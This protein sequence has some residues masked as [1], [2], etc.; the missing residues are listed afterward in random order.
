MNNERR[1][2]VFTFSAHF[3]FHFYEIAF[4][5][6]AVPLMFSLQLPLEDVLKLGFLMY[7]LFGVTSL[8]WGMFADRFG[9]RLSL[10][11]FFF[12]CSAGAFLTAFSESSGGIVFSLAVIGFFAG[13]YHPAGMGLISIGMKNRGMALG[14]NGTAGSIGLAAAPFVTGLLNW[15]VGWRMSYALIGIFG[16]VWGLLLAAC[17]IDETPVREEDIRSGTFS[18]EDLRRFLVLG[19]IIALGGLAYRINI[20]VLPAY[21]EF[22]A[23]FFGDLLRGLGNLREEGISTVAA[24]ALTSAIYVIGL[25]GQ[26]AGG[27]LSDRFDLK[28]LYLGFYTVSFPFVLMM[29]FYGNQVLAVAAAVYVFFAIGTQPIENSLIAKFTPARRRS[30]GYGITSVLVFGV[31]SLGIYAVALANKMWSLEAVYLMSGALILA[32]MLVIGFFIYS[33]RGQPVRN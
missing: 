33:L 15:L 17:P 11:I 28:W 4:P 30:T 12:G 14:I 1:I 3:L 26:L 21:L 8:P 22:K 7:L 20:V 9:N 19:L 13:I 31:G 16:I 32:I 18:R 10:I 2:T 5:A 27:R 25:F 24:T 29:A 23:G 6:M